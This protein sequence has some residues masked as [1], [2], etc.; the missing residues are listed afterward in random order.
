MGHTMIQSLGRVIDI[1]LGPLR[2]ITWWGQ[3]GASSMNKLSM[4]P[5]GVGATT[6][7]VESVIHMSS[8]RSEG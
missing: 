6:H 1:K 2:R 4:K 5:K 7:V 3:K 8:C